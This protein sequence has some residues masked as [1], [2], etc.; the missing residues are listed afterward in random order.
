MQ[1]IQTTMY[2]WTLPEKELCLKRPQNIQQKYSN[3]SDPE[4]RKGSGLC[5]QAHRAVC[6]LFISMSNVKQDIQNYGKS[7]Y[8]RSQQTRESKGN[9]TT[10]KVT[11]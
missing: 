6:N 2:S 7:H 3:K 10:G 11:K 8:V 1:S 5:L 4:R 9:E